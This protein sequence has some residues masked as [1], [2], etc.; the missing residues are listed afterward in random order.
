MFLE[1]QGFKRIQ[2]ILH[3]DNQ[4]AMKIIQNGR[5]SSGQKTKHMDNR[6]FWIKDHINSEHIEVRYCPTEKMIAD[7]LQNHYRVNYSG[8]FEI[9]Y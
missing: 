1:A 9:L 5:M 4:N 6:N 8:S 7:F 3:Q 2:K